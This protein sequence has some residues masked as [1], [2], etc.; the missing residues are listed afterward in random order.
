ML[1]LD[2]CF[3]RPLPT[4]WE[5]GAENGPASC[6]TPR[7]D[8]AIIVACRLESRPKIIG[9][10]SYVSSRCKACRTGAKHITSEYVCSENLRETVMRDGLLR[11]GRIVMSNV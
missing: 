7:A 9:G 2:R 10:V 8:V 4:R 6:S 11:L 5:A 3:R 1:R